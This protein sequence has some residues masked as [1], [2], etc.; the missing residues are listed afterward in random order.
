MQGYQLVRG[1]SQLA[2][3]V[4]GRSPGME[5]NP[6]RLSPSGP[7]W[8]GRQVLSGVLQQWMQLMGN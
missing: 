8:N 1:G 7:T 4:L 3:D 6:F 2:F 5:D